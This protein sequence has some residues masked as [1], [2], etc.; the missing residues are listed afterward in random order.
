MTIYK[1]SIND[2]YDYRFIN[3]ITPSDPDE[4]C[5]TIVSRV[6]DEL[7][8]E[9]PAETYEYGLR[10]VWEE[11]CAQEQGEH[12]CS[13]DYYVSH[14]Y[15]LISGECEI[16]NDEDYFSIALLNNEYIE[17]IILLYGPKKPYFDG[18]FFWCNGKHFNNSNEANIEYESIVFAFPSFRSNS[19]NVFD[20]IMSVMQREACHYKNSRIYACNNYCEPYEV[21]P[22][23]DDEIEAYNDGY[24]TYQRYKRS[25]EMQKV[26]FD[27]DDA[28]AEFD[29]HDLEYIYGESETG[30][31]V[32][33]VYDEYDGE[34]KKILADLSNREDY[35]L[36]F[37][38]DGYEYTNYEAV[39]KITDKT[40]ISE[41]ISAIEENSSVESPLLP[42]QEN[43]NIQIVPNVKVEHNPQKKQSALSSY[44]RSVF[45]R[46]NEREI[47]SFDKKSFIAYL[48]IPYIISFALA[49][50]LGICVANFRFISFALNRKYVSFT[51][52]LAD[53]YISYGVLILFGV[54]LILAALFQVITW[55]D[56]IGYRAWDIA[57][58]F[59][60]F[61]AVIACIAFFVWVFID[62]LSDVTPS[63]WNYIKWFFGAFI[64][65]IVCAA[66]TA[67]GIASVYYSCLITFV[68]ILVIYKDPDEL[69]KKQLIVRTAILFAILHIYLA[70]GYAIFWHL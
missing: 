15:N 40:T 21:Y 38:E 22:I 17:D 43:E 67:F 37:A 68:I 65:A 13:Y 29:A 64:S 12:F 55:L 61:A 48:N 4:I 1:A 10:N 36:E 52:L 54:M 39:W 57:I 24:L 45:E 18:E 49:E 2:L 9:P 27:I 14:I 30:A 32:I 46:S 51:D 33:Y 11:F 25:V 41:D 60:K 56:R 66:L 31:K 26:R 19:L 69:T 16:M 28:I 8:K 3:T 63:I 23:G 47:N 53:T 20:P 58:G 50:T 5:Q 59:L 42:V 6:I 7:K 44:F 70:A 34:T 35:I 62:G